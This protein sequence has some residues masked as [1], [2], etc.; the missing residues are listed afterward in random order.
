MASKSA[1]CTYH[2]CGIIIAKNP[3]ILSLETNDLQL[4][5]YLIH[6]LSWKD[7]MK[8]Y[9]SNEK[10]TMEMLKYIIS[11]IPYFVHS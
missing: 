8:G 4:Q 1:L 11:K 9:Q 6:M 3:V 5:M 7:S 10:F 2:W